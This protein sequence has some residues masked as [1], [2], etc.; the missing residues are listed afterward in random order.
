M[1]AAMVYL[2][3]VGVWG[4]EPAYS[5]AR[6]QETFP[7]VR[8]ALG[9]LSGA[10]VSHRQSISC[11]AFV[12]ARRALSGSKRRFPARADLR[13]GRRRRPG[14]RDVGRRLRQLSGCPGRSSALSVFHSKST[15]M[16]LLYGRAGR[17]SC[18][19]GGFRPGQSTRTTSR[20]TPAPAASAC[21]S[22][23]R[24]RPTRWRRRPR[25]RCGRCETDRYRISLVLAEGM[26]E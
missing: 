25:S 6:W 23:G 10:G 20:A 2:Q 22:G 24:P 16:A 14:A 18:K 12:W 15:S 8:A 19:N 5:A 1:A 26:M 21:G 3:R 4:A 7:A 11:G 17:L 9:R 13:G